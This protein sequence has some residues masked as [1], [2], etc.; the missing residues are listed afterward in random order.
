MLGAGSPP[1][2]RDGL[3]L[4]GAILEHRFDD[5]IAAG[6]RRVVGGRRD[7]RQQRVALGGGGAASSSTCS[8][9][10]VAECALPCSALASS[11]SISTTVDAGA[12]R[13][14]GDAG[15]HEAGAEDAEPLHLGRRDRG[16]A[17]RALVELLHRARTA[18]A[19]SRRLPASAGSWRTSATPPAARGPSAAAGP[20]TRPAGWRARPDNC[21]RSRGDRSRWRP[22]RSSCRPWSRP[23]RPAG[24]SRRRPTGSSPCRRP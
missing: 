6:E 20:H 5:E 17:A 18:C 19:S 22:G 13:D 11:R 14:V 10:S 24:G 2:L 9:I 8:A 4:D 1:R 21:R 15:A 12:R 23:A 16:G 3:G 7:A